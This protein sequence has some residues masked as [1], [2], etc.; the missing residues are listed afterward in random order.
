MQNERRY[1]A[2]IAV[3]VVHI[4]IGGICVFYDPELLSLGTILV[5]SV[6][7]YTL[8]RCSVV[9]P[10]YLALVDVE[11]PPALEM[12]RLRLP[13]PQSAEVDDE[14][15]PQLRFCTTCHM[16]QPIRTKHCEDCDRCVRTYDHHC[17]W[18]GTCVGEN[19]RSWFLLYLWAEFV[20]LT[21]FTVSGISG[22]V[23]HAGDRDKL[24][25]M[26]LLIL[27][28]MIMFVFI[29]MTGILGSYHVFL[30]IT[31]LTT[32]EHASWYKITY[33]SDLKQELGS[34][35]SQPSWRGNLRQFFQLGEF[36]RDLSAIDWKL[37]PQYPIVPVLVR[38]SC[39]SC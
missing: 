26:T 22:I 27:C 11:T 25:P 9:D 28:I 34:P 33:L 21:W 15:P 17:P 8:W 38:Q 30:A 4:L 37:G 1:Y 32:W 36:R 20:N 24:A 7:L 14:H 3:G 35:F 23:A 29:L 19:N 2:P 6:A 16:Y 12:S 10:G 18:I 31:N 5:F 39:D 13:I